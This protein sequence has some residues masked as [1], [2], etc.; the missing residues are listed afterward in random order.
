MDSLD[1]LN[2]LDVIKNEETYT[3]RLKAIKEA[4][5]EY[6]DSR[7]IAAT[8][9]LANKYL[10]NAK[11]AE[12]SRSILLEEAS[13]DI[14]RLKIEKLAELEER[15][16]KLEGKLDRIEASR[17]AAQAALAA[18]ETLR[19]TNAKRTQ[20]LLAWEKSLFEIENNSKQLEEKLTSKFNRIVDIIKE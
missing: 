10:K 15:E 14:E 13:K 12:D 9:E 3:A 16:T 20:E 18:Q 6:A 4:E 17:A 8:V 5:K 1:L 19:E 2:I 7:F 11:E